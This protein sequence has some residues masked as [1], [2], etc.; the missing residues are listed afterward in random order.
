MELARDVWNRRGDI[1]RARA[2]FSRVATLQGRERCRHF[3]RGIFRV[4]SGCRAGWCCD[5]DT[6]LFAYS[7]CFGRLNCRC[8]CI[9]SHYSDYNLVKSKHGKVVILL[10]GLSRG[11]CDLASSFKSFTAHAW[12]GAAL[13]SK[14]K[15]GETAILGAGSWGTALAWLW[16][17]DGRQVSL[18]GHD[19]D[20]AARMRETREN[21]EYLPGLKLPESVRVTSRLTDCTRSDLI[22]FAT[23]STALR[24]VATQLQEAIGN[25][26]AVLLSCVKGIE[27]GTGMR[28]SQILSELFPDQKVAVLS[29]PNLAAEV[30]Q[31][32]PTATVIGCND[33]ECATNLQGILGSPRFRV[34]TSQEVTSIE[35]GG[36]LKNV[37][38][39]AAGISD[40]LGLGDNSKAALVTRS[41][42]ELVRLGVA[43]GGTAQAFYG[44]SGAGDLIVTCYSDR[45]RNHT[46]G[47]RLGRGESL[48]QISQSM[49]MVAEGIP[50]ARSAFECARQLKIE[51]PIID[52][53]YAVLYEQKKPTGALEE[54]LSREQKAEH[55]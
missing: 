1:E 39:V 14:V 16:G 11:S 9:T 44:L 18:W 35:L 43:M 47:K 8:S 40:G 13:Y 50:T 34:Y 25:G 46:V 17:K 33:A 41:L 37:F 48:M 45:S 12:N 21:S 54:V 52:Q 42:A 23:P 53:V 55:L 2:F 30:V 24:K 32:F 6:D 38:A 31:N 51:T 29:G 20:R 49:R 27:H 5:L 19:R 22:V 10:V 4:G 15:I 26:R 3:S 28:M 7:L 36:A